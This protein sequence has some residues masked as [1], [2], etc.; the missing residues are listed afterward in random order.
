VYC[1]AFFAET[2]FINPRPCSCGLQ[3]CPC[4][5]F[6][7]FAASVA[8]GTE[9]RRS[10][11][12]FS[13]EVG[14]YNPTA[15]W[16]PGCEF[17]SASSSGCVVAY[18]C[19]HSTAPAYLA[20][21]L[22]LTADVPHLP[23]ARHYKCRQHD[24]ASSAATGHFQWLQLELGT[25]CHKWQEPPTHYCSFG[26]RQKHTCMFWLS[27]SDWSEATVAPYNLLSESF[28]IAPFIKR[29]S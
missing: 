25:V 15:S 21:S 28:D 9:C 7:K 26:E 27:F 13:Q 6:R 24:A 4:R 17:Q 3:S 1:Y 20:H 2:R 29:S 23:T 16:S 8:V 19:V 5:Y 18:P 10:A 11:R 12:M 14:T 22:Q